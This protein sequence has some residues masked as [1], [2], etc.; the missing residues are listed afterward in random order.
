MGKKKAF[1]IYY[2]NDVIVYRLPDDEAGQLFKSLFPYVKEHLIPDFENSPALA[3]AFDVLRLA[4][5]RDTEKYEQICKINAENGRKGGLAKASGRRRSLSDSSEAKR[6]LANLADTE[7]EKE[8]DSDIDTETNL[9]DFDSDPVSD[10]YTLEEI[11]ECV[12][13]GKVN[14]T[15]EGVKAF[16]EQIE[17][18]GWTMYGKPITNLLRAVREY[19]KRHQ[20]NDQGTPAKPPAQP[21]KNAFHNFEQ[22]DY[23]YDDLESK[24]L[25]KI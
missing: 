18:D 19:A 7:T 25:G 23:D 10:K 20:G 16:Y 22:R 1:L 14:I 13:D 17:A 24:L 21:R 11:R 3:M 2:D 4:I 9:S 5:D 6:G 8:K 12:K 15:D